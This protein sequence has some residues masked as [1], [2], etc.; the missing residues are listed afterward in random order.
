MQVTAVYPGTFDPITNGHLDIIARGV[1]LFDRIIVALLKN[2][3]KEPLLP[4]DE[5]IEIVRAVVGGFPNVTVESFDGLL[6]DYARARGAQAIVRGLRA[7]SDFEFE[8][9]MALMNRR[10][11]AGVETVYMMPSETYSY[12][13]SRLVKEVAHLGGDITGLVPPEVVLR[14]KARYAA[15]GG[16]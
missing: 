15:G 3:D 16:R 13:S 14:L 2:A 8:F 6:V 11:E 5:R 10:L 12:V 1:R 7:L 9:Q 4:L